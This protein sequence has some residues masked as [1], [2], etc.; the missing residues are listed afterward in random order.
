M[1]LKHFD[2]IYII[3]LPSRSDRRIEMAE[4][5]ER[6][7]L[8]YES[9]NVHLFEAVRPVDAGPFPT[10]GTR[11]CFMS[12]L[13]VLEDAHKRGLR[14]VLILEDDCNFTAD[15]EHVLSEFSHSS[16]LESWDLFY[17]GTLTDDLILD[18][19]E[20]FKLVP[21]NQHLMGAHFLAIQGRVLPILIHYL[22]AMLERP[23]GHPEGGPMH[24]DGAYSWFRTAFP[25]YKTVLCE[26]PLAYQRSSRTDIH[27]N[28][29]YDRLPVVREII[30]WLR[31]VKNMLAS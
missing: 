10:I 1:S 7:G 21:P 23:G 14:S 30:A 17:G 25:H 13:G 8:T 27:G 16:F 20:R 26:P 19:A 28:S 2:G 31:K 24:V 5:L 4:Q 15:C 29:W 3:N 11:G 22:K 18:G 6:V 12:H 9:D